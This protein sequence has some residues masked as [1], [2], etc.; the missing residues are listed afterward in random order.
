MH[1]AFPMN[2]TSL[3]EV[4]SSPKNVFYP[5]YDHDLTESL[6]VLNGLSSNKLHCSCIDVW[7]SLSY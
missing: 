4:M 1:E 2:I 6:S 7:S 3:N 5:Q